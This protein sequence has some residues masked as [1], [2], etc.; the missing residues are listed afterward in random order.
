L[1]KLGYA[2]G[3]DVSIPSSLPALADQS[4]SIPTGTPTPGRSL[5]PEPPA[6]KQDPGFGPEQA[7]GALK[8]GAAISKL[9]KP[10]TGDQSTAAEDAVDGDNSSRPDWARQGR[11]VLTRACRCAESGTTH[12]GIDARIASTI[13]ARQRNREGFGALWPRI[14][15]RPS[16]SGLAPSAG[17]EWCRFLLDIR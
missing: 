4:L 9:V 8:A 12:R 10:K 11:S 16:L 1:R 15:R 14:V 3:G 6:P 7:L 2:D 13:A 5:M 17:D